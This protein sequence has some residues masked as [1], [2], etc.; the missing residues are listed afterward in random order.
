MPRI[1][2]DIYAFELSKVGHGYPLY[3]PDPCG[4]Y[5]RVRT[6]DVGH[7]VEGKFIRHFNIFYEETHGIY[8]Q[9]RNKLQFP[10]GFAVL[11]D[12]GRDPSQLAHRYEL[13]KGTYKSRRSIGVKFNVDITGRVT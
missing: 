13:A 7:I 3:E 1:E 5:D 9:Y 12:Q 8:D 10:D 11:K 2:S 6:G 4:D